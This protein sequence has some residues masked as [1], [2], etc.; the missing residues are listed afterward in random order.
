MIRHIN[1]IKTGSARQ[2]PFL[3]MAGGSFQKKNTP[4][5]VL[6]WNMKPKGKS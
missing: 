6:S 5:T 4:F 1:I 2:R 3:T